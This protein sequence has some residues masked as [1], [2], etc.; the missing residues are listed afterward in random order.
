MELNTSCNRL[1]TIDTSNIL[2]FFDLHKDN[3]S[4]VASM[5]VKEVADFKWDEEQDDSIAYLSKQK[6]FVLRGKETE[7]GI[8]CEGYICSFRGLVV[9]TVL[10][11]SFL[12]P[13]S[14]PDRRFLIDSEIKSLRN[15]KVMLERLKMEEAVQF[16]EKNP[17]PRLWSLL[18]EVALLRMDITTAEYAFVKMH[19]YCGL[20]FCKKIMEI[21]DLNYK[22]AEVFIH[23][24]RV[25]DAEKLLIEQD[26]RD[27][28]IDMH[29]KCD[30]W[31]RVL[32]LVSISSN[33]TDDKQ[34]IEALKN[35]ADYHRDRQRWKEAA[36]HYELAGNLDQL[37]ICYIHLDD[38][39]GLENLAKKLPDYDILLTQIADLFASSGLCENAVQ[40][41]L[42]CGQ[43]AESLDTCV[44]LNNWDKAV[45][46]S[47][48]HNLRDVDVLVGKYVKELN[49]SSERSLAAVQLYRRAG[50][51]LDGV[52]IVY[53]VTLF[54][55]QF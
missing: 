42:R 8:S 43:I 13:N 10:L 18:S 50:R 45:A 51:F 55:L 46:L 49:E 47:R 2:R 48:T 35:V 24:G 27:L 33:A 39:Y 25:N 20:R 19:D 3:I 40:C 6:L 21:Q 34:K 37:M 15:A 52:R 38:F 36:D 44:Q 29:K 12:L 26:R 23:L 9:R 5:D 53:M 1:A 30:E 4:K 17:H 41:F 14:T 54:L 22:K 7:E 32:R 28:A 11:D 31:S 16:I